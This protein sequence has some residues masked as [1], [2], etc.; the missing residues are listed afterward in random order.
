MPLSE[1]G[2]TDSAS[3]VIL[4]SQRTLFRTFQDAETLGAWRTPDGMSAH[5]VDFDP[6]IGGGYRMILRYAG[7]DAH[8]FGKTR[9]GEDEVV[10]RFTDRLPD[11]KMVE[12]VS[13][14]TDVPEFKGEMV[15]T[16]LFEPA[17]DGTKVT[18]RAEHVPHGI[19][20]ADHREGMLMAL[21]N[22]ARLTE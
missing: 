13:F 9:P 11:E 21:R 3:R 19:S 20:A 2:R 4:A 17:H 7:A 5:F 14:V 15:M 10:V 22:L 8:R 12:A 6:R 16:T 18:I 1:G